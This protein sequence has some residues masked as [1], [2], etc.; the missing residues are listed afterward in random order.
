MTKAYAKRTVN[1]VIA[2]DILMQGTS[3]SGR[4]S[5]I[6]KCEELGIDPWGYGMKELMK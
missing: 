3:T 4:T 2:Q 1:W 5:C 6:T